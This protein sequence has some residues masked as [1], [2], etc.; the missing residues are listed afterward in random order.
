MI[1]EKLMEMMMRMAKRMMVKPVV[2]Y[3]LI[4]YVKSKNSLL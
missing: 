4:T 1:V 3:I 2:G